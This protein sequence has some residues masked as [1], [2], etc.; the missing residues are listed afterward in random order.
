MKRNHLAF[1][2]VNILNP[3]GA[4]EMPKK[5]VAGV[6]AG[7]ASAGVTPTAVPAVGDVPTTQMYTWL[8]TTVEKV[9]KITNAHLD[10]LTRFYNEDMGI[11]A[12]DT[13]EERREKF[14][15]WLRGL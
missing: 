11:V 15:R 2:L 7:I 3:N 4:I 13:L 1:P 8:P 9:S 14:V 12:A 5:L 10:T 6:G